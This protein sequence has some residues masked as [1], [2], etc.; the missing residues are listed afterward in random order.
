M[1]YIAQALVVCLI[2]FTALAM[3]VNPW[4]KGVVV[5][6]V[7][8]VPLYIFDALLLL[9]TAAF[10]YAVSLRLPTDPAP[11]NRL[12]L[13]ATGAYILYQIVV[14]VPVAVLLYDIGPGHAYAGITARL[15]LL[16]IPFF[17]YVGL[18]HM[19]PDRVVALVNAAAIGLLL[20]AV[21]RYAFIGAEGTWENG[22]YR[23]RVLWGGSTLLFGWLA[24][25]G[26]FLERSAL[27]AYMFG[28]AGVIGI[29]L[30]NH[31]SGY[32]A[33]MLALAVL[34][35]LSRSITRRVV[36]IAAIVIIGAVSLGAVSP[37]IRESAA[38][39]LTTMFNARSD[40]NAWDRVERT[41]LAW[42]YVKSYPLGDYVWTRR[43]YLVDLGKDGFEPHNF[44]IGALDKQGAVAAG[45]LF[46]VI[47]AALWVGYT[48]RTR[49]RLGRVMT[50]YLVFYLV[51]CLFNT[52]FDAVESVTL[53]ALA[54]A[55]VLFANQ[56]SR[57]TSSD[58]P[59]AAP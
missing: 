5:I 54:V 13:R 45:L 58:E 57:I 12:V 24:I 9:C 14:V 19:Q 29:V 18:R 52:N 30:V 32:I 28:V 7:G 40:A 53:F 39:S 16:L 8:P 59:T 31:R 33:L 48:T 26:L 42:D 51:F 4:F 22:V 23:L 2:V 35:L 55:L 17:Y 41:A 56:S 3:A 34:L 44:V 47:A 49:S 46:L 10:F 38:Y 6:S 1:K 21:Y 37:T 25:T 50:A 20:Y 43:Y 36:T 27:R 15:G 11:G